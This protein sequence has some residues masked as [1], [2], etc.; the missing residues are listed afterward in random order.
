MT[1]STEDRIDN[2]THDGNSNTP[3]SVNG[4]SAD[5]LQSIIGNIESLEEKKAMFAEHIK[6]AKKDAKLRGYDVKTLNT[7][8]KLRKM[9]SV[10]IEKEELL[11]EAYKTALG[12]S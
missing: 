3:S 4:V 9:D 5:E 1:L 10:S 8:L 6:D 11:L 2:E 7:I 12:M